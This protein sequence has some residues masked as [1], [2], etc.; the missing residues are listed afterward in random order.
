VAG[1]TLAAAVAAS[2]PV[3]AEAAAAGLGRPAL[4]FGTGIRSGDG[5]VTITYLPPATPTVTPTAR[6]PAGQVTAPDDGLF[7]A[8]GDV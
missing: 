3:A 7:G 2:R 1:T 4:G 5:Q 8:G 6:H